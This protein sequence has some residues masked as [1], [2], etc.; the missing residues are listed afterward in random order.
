MHSSLVSKESLAQQG[1]DVP[2][3][4]L[5]PEFLQREEQ[6]SPR[7]CGMG[8]TQQRHDDLCRI[9]MA[10]ID[11]SEHGSVADTGTAGLTGKTGELLPDGNV[12][13]RSIECPHD[14][15]DS[16][17]ILRADRPIQIDES[18]FRSLAPW[19]PLPI[20]PHLGPA[21]ILP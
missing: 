11:Q 21:Q 14:L 16:R 7:P 10:D 17:V 8:L 18:Q 12:G 15:R 13:G 3:R 2:D 5:H 6:G 9:L 1:N 4:D 20:L 19:V